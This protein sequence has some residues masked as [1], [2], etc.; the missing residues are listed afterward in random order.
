LPGRWNRSIKI[1]AVSEAYELPV[2][3]IQQF[4]GLDEENERV[5]KPYTPKQMALRLTA[6]HFKVVTAT[7]SNILSS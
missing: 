2:E 4:L 1:K 5:R 3:M 7:V 6:A